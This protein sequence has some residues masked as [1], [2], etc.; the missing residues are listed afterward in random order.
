ML[1][2]NL[3]IQNFNITQKLKSLLQLSIT[4]KIYL[5]RIFLDLLY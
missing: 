2:Q 5:S 3:K 4:Y 1:F